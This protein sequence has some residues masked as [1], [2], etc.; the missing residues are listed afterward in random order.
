M[1]I[2]FS[3]SN[4]FRKNNYQLA[5]IIYEYRNKK[6]V[7]KI[8]LLKES[9]PHL[10]KIE[11]NYLEIKKQFILT[12]KITLIK[13]NYIDFEYLPF[14]SLESIIEKY[15]INHQFEDTETILKIYLSFISNLKE[16]KTSIYKNKEFIKI[17]DQ[18]KLYDQK[19]EESCLIKSVLDY[20]LD[21]LLYDENKNNLYLIDWEWILNFPLPKKYIIFR[22]IFYL[23]S[24]FQSLIVS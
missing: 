1:K 10:K 18:E 13:E 21:N 16:I 6:Y 5:T 14:P 4:L 19:K 8:A 9:L 22:A 15:L 23:A 24:K 20:N 3:R 2:L 11:N 7:R 17:F 12:P